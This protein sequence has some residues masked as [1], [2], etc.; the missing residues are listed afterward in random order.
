[1]RVLCLLEVKKPLFR[2]QKGLVE[3]IFFVDISIIVTYLL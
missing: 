3:E 2:R 1:M